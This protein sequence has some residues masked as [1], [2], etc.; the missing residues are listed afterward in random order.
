[1][2][3]RKKKTHYYLM[4]IMLLLMLL[5]IIIADAVP[6]YAKNIAEGFLEEAVFGQRIAPDTGDSAAMIIW[7]LL[8]AVA[9][10]GIITSLI[11]L[12]HNRKDKH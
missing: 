1:M 2:K 6:V 11:M 12:I 9:L 10:G 7:V 4:R 3:K 8:A 5:V